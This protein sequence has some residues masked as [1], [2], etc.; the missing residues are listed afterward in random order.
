MGHAATARNI[1]RS[2]GKF[3]RGVP[4]ER[5]RPLTN[6]GNA[7]QIFRF[8]AARKL[9]LPG[10]AVLRLGHAG[11]THVWPLIERSDVSVLEEIFLG[12]EYAL[13]VAPPRVVFDLGANFGA[14]SVYFAQ[15]WPKARIIAVEPNPEMFRR[16]RKTTEGYPGITCLNYAVGETD[17][18]ADFIVSTDHIGSSLLRPDPNGQRIKVEVRSLRTLMAETGTKHI[19]VLKFDV[20][21]AEEGLFRDASVLANVDVLVGEV[22]KDLIHISEADFLQR[23]ADFTLEKRSES[24]DLFVMTARRKQAAQQQA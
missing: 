14:A 22:H 19:D 2:L 17:G 16:L 20:E 21:G 13:D 4:G 12:H 23:F 10:A 7:A 9:G 15:A 3:A 1:V 24:G 5:R 18:T 8:L 6:M 11:A